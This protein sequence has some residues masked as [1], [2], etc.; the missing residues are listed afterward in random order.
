ML[1]LST[2]QLAHMQ[3]LG[4]VYFFQ[5]ALFTVLAFVARGRSALQW[6]HSLVKSARVN[7]SFIVVN[8]LLAPLTLITASAATSTYAKLG[9]P[10]IPETFWASMP[11][12]V[13]AILA[14][15]LIDFIHYWAHRLMHEPL[16]WPMHAVH[17]S[18]TE[19]NYTSWYRGHAVE[20]VFLSFVAIFA[21]SWFG[22]SPELVVWVVVARAFH[23]QYCHTNIDWTHGKFEPLLASPRFHRWHH[24]E[25]EAAYGKNLALVMPIW[26]HMFGTYYSPGPCNVRTGFDDGPGDNFLKLMAYP[27]VEWGRMLG[28][29]F[30]R[31]KP[32]AD[33]DMQATNN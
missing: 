9:I 28:G 6:N 17:H 8:M 33:I 14:L 21:A 16:F 4:W 22:A 19:L 25:H 15:I 12:I 27:F 2:D 30:G 7:W 29:A 18:D 3:S 26:D 1:N 24:A 10:Q 11:I 13:P 32:A 31:N 23:Q 20:G 5:F